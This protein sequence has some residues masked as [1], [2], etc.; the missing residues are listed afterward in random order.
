MPYLLTHPLTY[1][2]ARNLSLTRPHFA[3][4]VTRE[5]RAVTGRQSGTPHII[6]SFTKV[7]D[8]PFWTDEDVLGMYQAGYEH[9]REDEEEVIL[10]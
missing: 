2:P 10:N 1:P 7:V 5:V 6:I 4:R 3:V 8:L 9:R